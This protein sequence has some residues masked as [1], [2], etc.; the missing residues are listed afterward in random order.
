M[1]SLVDELKTRARLRLNAARR[2]NVAPADSTDAVDADKLRLRHCLNQVAREAGFAHFEHARR[3]LG[4]DAL[5]GEDLGAFW[6]AR[7]CDRLLNEWFA[8]Y[9]QAH[10]AHQARSGRG[11]YLV[12]YRRQFVLVQRD[13]ITALGVDPADSAWQQA[14]N[15]LVRSYGSPAWFALAAQ[16]LRAQRTASTVSAPTTP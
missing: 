2:G 16:R 7:E 14:Q 13:Y 15:D 1:N 9:E 10:E 11:T 8:R 12:P 4:G 3:V 6:H 5:P